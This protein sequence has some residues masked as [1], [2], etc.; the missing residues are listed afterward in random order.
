MKSGILMLNVS[1]LIGML[2]CIVLAS[3]GIIIDGMIWRYSNRIFK[4]QLPKKIDPTAAKC[5]NDAA[6]IEGWN[7]CLAKINQ[8]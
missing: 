6:Y 3:I 7:D 1:L 5:A 4:E 8:E 2:F